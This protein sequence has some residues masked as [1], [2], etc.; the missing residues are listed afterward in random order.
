[1]AEIYGYQSAFPIEISNN[2]MYAGL[3][4]REYFAACALQGWLAAGYD[5]GMA[6][7]KAVEYADEL[8]EALNAKKNTV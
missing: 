1:M 4:K 8:I 3:S 7:R 6:A 2:G 5:N